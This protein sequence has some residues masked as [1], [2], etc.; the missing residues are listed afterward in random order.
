MEEIRLRPVRPEDGAALLAIYAPY[1]EKT[2]ITF[3]YD[4]PTVEEFCR[5]IE[6]IRKTYPYIVLEQG[7][8]LLG[9]AY[10]GPF[11]ERAAY[12]WAAEVTI[13]LGENCR[14]RGLGPVL[15]T[16]LEKLCAAQHILNLYACIGYPETPDKY[17]TDNS[18]RFHAHLG[19]RLVGEFRQCGYKFGRWYHMVW[20]EKLL[21][22]H[23]TPMEPL[24]P[25]PDLPREV[26]KAAGLDV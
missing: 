9:Y 11:K 10:A 6:K 1:V 18:A 2:A 24:I 26:L 15:Y 8:Q 12:D 7:G 4:V 23:K 16:V 20:M 25:F 17:L 22:Q 13:Y 14:G 5:R 3:E 19:Y 21:G